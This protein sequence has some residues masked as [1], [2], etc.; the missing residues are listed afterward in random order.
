VEAFML[1]VQRK[2]KRENPASNNQDVSA[3]H[4][5]ALWLD[6]RELSEQQAMTPYHVVIGTRH[7]AKMKHLLQDCVIGLDGSWLLKDPSD[8]AVLSLTLVERRHSHFFSWQSI[9][10]ARKAKRLQKLSCRP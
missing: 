6:E 5:E 7:L 9:S 1:S 3:I 10:L 8:S 2:R 4:D